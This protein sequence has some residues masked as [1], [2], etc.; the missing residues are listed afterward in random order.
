[1]SSLAYDR[2]IDVVLVTRQAAG[3]DITSIYEQYEEVSE[4]K[5]SF[6]YLL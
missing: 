4:F 5:Y 1:M 3:Q 6:H 2:A